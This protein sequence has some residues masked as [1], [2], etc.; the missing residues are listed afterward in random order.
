MNIVISAPDVNG[1]FGQLFWEL[2]V[3]AWD[4]VVDIGLRSHYVAARRVAPTMTAQGGGLI[5]NVSSS[6][7]AH[8]AAHQYELG[9]GA[10]RTSDLVGLQLV[11]HVRRHAIQRPLADT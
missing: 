11:G 8:Y 9:A 10:G 4:E 5:V 7:A 3:A 6:G 1:W 2:P